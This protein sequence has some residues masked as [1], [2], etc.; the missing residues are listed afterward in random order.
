MTG[1]ESLKVQLEMSRQWLMALMSDVQGAEMTSPTSKGGNHPLW[2]FGHMI[3]AEAGMVHGFVL[4]QPSPL[5]KWDA[6]FGMGSQPVSDINAYPSLIEL[7]SEFD[8]VRA[9]TLKLL[10][11]MSDSDL[12]KPSKAP[13]ELANMFG[14]VGQCFATVGLHAAFHAGQVADARRAAGKRPVF[15]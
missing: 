12:D 13:P 11:G 14:T 15:G 4:G 1:I 5:A 10:A 3:C 2:A 7:R 9:S 8:K 6:L